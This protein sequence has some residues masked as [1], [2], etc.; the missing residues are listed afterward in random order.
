MRQRDTPLRS[1]C[2]PNASTC[3]VSCNN[4]L[5]GDP[6]FGQVKYCRITFQCGDHKPK[7]FQ[8]QE[9]RSATMA[10]DAAPSR[11]H[12]DP[13]LASGSSLRYPA[14]ARIGDLR[15]IVIALNDET[16]YGPQ[17]GAFATLQTRTIA[18]GNPTWTS[19][20]PPWQLLFNTI[21]S[22]L[23]HDV[24]PTIDVQ[25]QEAAREWDEELADHLTNAAIS[26]LLG[27]YDSRVGRDY[28]Q[29]QHGL[30]RL[31][32][33]M[34]SAMWGTMVGGGLE[35]QDGTQS[36]PP[37]V[38]Q[39]RKRLLE[40]SWSQMV[41]QSLTS[42]GNAHDDPNSKAIGSAFEG[43]VRLEAESQGPALD[44]LLRRYGSELS[45]FA[46]FHQTPAAKALLAVYEALARDAKVNPNG[47]QT[48][49]VL[50][51]QRS[52][53]MHAVAWR[54]AYQKERSSEAQGPMMPPVAGQTGAR[55]GSG[56]RP[57]PAACCGASVPP[58]VKVIREEIVPSAHSVQ[59]EAVARAPDGDYV[60]A[61]S[62]N[63]EKPWAMRV[64]ATGRARWE[65]VSPVA[66]QG[67]GSSG[68][69]GVAVLPD[70]SSMLC[71]TANLNQP[72][73]V[74]WLVHLN[75]RGKE[76][77]RMTIEPKDYRQGDFI[78]LDRCLRWGDGVAL[79]GS[80]TRNW[81]ANGWLVKLDASG[82]I[83]WQRMGPLGREDAFE[84]RDHELLLLARAGRMDQ[85]QRIGSTGDILSQSEVPDQAQFLRPLASRDPIR[86]L[87]MQMEGPSTVLSLNKQLR[88]LGKP[89]VV[90]NV[91][92]KVA[93]ELEDR[94]A[95]VFGNIR[96]GGQITAAIF[97][98]YANGAV[99][100]LALRPPNQSGWINDAVLTGD[101]NTFVMVRDAGFDDAGV[102]RSVLAWVTIE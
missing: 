44:A 12:P 23:T 33:A 56:P 101:A 62:E 65:Y 13:S 70:G 17:I 93:Y 28:L 3:L 38:M 87:S 86:V 25:V 68:F 4:E 40:L 81:H 42:A 76:L 22:D 51:L 1:R 90:G 26:E 73:Q 58:H 35:N 7:E 49:V 99:G 8:I 84:T 31:Q 96:P 91:Y 30:Q 71:A 36:S 64:D 75:A 11:S 79:L 21:R 63:W 6:D 27:F 102:D 46:A 66:I 18:A 78:T 55:P 37:E 5:A 50:A 15:D 100:T 60:I 82:N 89:T 95:I 92:V 67:R 19:E 14:N 53:T 74:G 72:H 88:P 10:C 80:V 94:S 69:L 20:N 97:R 2:S 41:I 52:A 24:Q 59:A 61:G 54:A 45:Q 85:I 98:I 29:L 83:Q 32:V 47:S 57:G 48:A 9:G 77:S 34:A 16:D 43:V 39:Q